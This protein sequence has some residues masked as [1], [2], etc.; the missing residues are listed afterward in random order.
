MLS[1]CCL[2]S[3]CCQLSSKGE[4]VS[5]SQSLVSKADLVNK[6]GVE[7]DSL[8]EVVVVNDVCNDQS[9]GMP[10][11]S[12]GVEG[13]EPESVKSLATIC[14]DFLKGITGSVH[15]QTFDYNP[16]MVEVPPDDSYAQ[17]EQEAS[18]YWELDVLDLGIQIT[19]VQGRLRKH[20]SFWKDVLQAP[21]PILDC[22]NCGYHLPLKFMPPP[23]SSDNHTSAFLQQQFV[24]DA[25]ADLLKNRCAEQVNEKPYI[26]SPL[27]VVSNSTGKLRLVLNLR[28]L[29]QFLHVVSFKY[30][31]LHIAAL[32]FE[33]DEFLIKFDL[34]SG[35]HHVDCLELPRWDSLFLPGRS[36]SNLFRGVPNTPVLALRLDFRENRD[37]IMGTG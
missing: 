28:Y 8:F 4:S 33:E 5:F 14:V 29:N 1:L 36:G 17:L 26:C 2:G 11:T 10:L 30:E 3:S 22:I 37:I 15:P 13:A 21:P 6:V 32:M 20:I 31:N 19:N 34:K 7:N 18:E 27:L 25:V 23:Y 9:A 16:D 12:K 35:Y 24:D